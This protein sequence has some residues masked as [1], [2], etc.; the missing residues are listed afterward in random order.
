M[1][2]LRLQ[3]PDLVCFS[4]MKRLVCTA[5]VFVKGRAKLSSSIVIDYCDTLSPFTDSTVFLREDSDVSRAL[6]Y[7]L[8]LNVIGFTESSLNS[9]DKPGDSSQLPTLSLAIMVP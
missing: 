9:R 4:S 8:S 2:D 1:E 5:P 7:S 3:Y 6:L